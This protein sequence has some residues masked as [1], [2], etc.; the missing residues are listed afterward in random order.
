MRLVTTEERR[1]AIRPWE[2]R[3]LTELT[4]ADPYDAMLASV[5]YE[6]RSHAIVDALGQ[7]PV[8]A[9]AIEFEDRQTD[10]YAQSRQ[11]FEDAGFDI[12]QDWDELFLP[13]V[14]A[15]LAH[16]PTGGRVLV[17]ISSMSRPRIAATVQAVSQLPLG[18]ELTV[19]FLYAPAAYRDPGDLPPGVLSL[20]PVGPFYSGRL[21]TRSDPVA[22]T[23]LGYEP[24]KAAGALDS[25]EVDQAIVFIPD[26][27][28]DRFYDRVIEANKGLLDS[29][30]GYE[31]HKYPVDD[32]FEI[33]TLL[34]GSS[35][36]LLGAELSPAILPL[37]PKVFALAACLV[38]AAHYPRISVWRASFGQD[39]EAVPHEPQGYVCGITTS[40]RPVPPPPAPA[41]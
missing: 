20:A 9:A 21:Q 3:D 12:R 22:L 14:L 39:E 17:D 29:H 8:L 4:G 2:T 10:E 40:V 33:F 34:E 27:F 15:W 28:D 26:G 31:Q 32:P 6:P 35:L 5:G 1:V 18:A 38:A 24:H 30:H 25:L 37:G 13:F 36:S 7:T 11:C 41:D 16:V 19:D 23:G